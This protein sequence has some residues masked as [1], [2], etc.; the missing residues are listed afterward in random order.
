MDNLHDA[1][2]DQKE[3]EDVISFGNQSLNESDLAELEDEL[4]ELVKKESEVEQKK[5]EE[6]ERDADL[7]KQLESLEL[8]TSEMKLDEKV[9]IGESL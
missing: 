5:A 7:L 9:S 1:L 6:E 3:V 2:A 4:E 8:K